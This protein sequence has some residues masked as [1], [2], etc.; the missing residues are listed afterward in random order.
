MKRTRSKKAAAMA[1]LT[2]QRP[3]QSLS[4]QIKSDSVPSQEQLRAS[5]LEYSGLK[6]EDL[7]NAAKCLVDGLS[8]MDTKFFQNLGKVKSAIDVIAWKTR[9]E[10]ATKLLQLFDV[11]VTPMKPS[12][13]TKVKAR[14]VDASWLSESIGGV[15]APVKKNAKGLELEITNE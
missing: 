15:N 6:K 3:D 7:Q 2:D 8:A 14:V 12:A 11:R 10:S 4:T 5:I 13:V 9:I 1:I